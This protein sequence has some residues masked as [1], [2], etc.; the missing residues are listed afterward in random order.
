MRSS[1]SGRFVSRKRV[2]KSLSAEGK[3]SAWILGLLPVVVF[4]FLM[5]TNRAYF[6]P[7]LTSVLG[8]ILLGVA[9]ALMAMATFWMRKLVRMEV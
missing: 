5:L 7:M 3:M 1:S 9:V 4:V 2:V 8:L 6:E